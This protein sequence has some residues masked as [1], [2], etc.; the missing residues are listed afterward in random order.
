MSNTDGIIATAVCAKEAISN[1]W[2]PVWIDEK[3][4]KYIKSVFG[5][6]VENGFSHVKTKQPAIVAGNLVEYSFNPGQDGTYGDIQQRVRFEP[7]E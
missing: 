4:L 6:S 7:Y 5:P 1:R 2:F 3:G